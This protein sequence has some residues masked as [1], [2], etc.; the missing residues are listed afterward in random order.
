MTAGLHCLISGSSSLGANE[1]L[2]WGNDSGVDT[3]ASIFLSNAD[4][5]MFYPTLTVIKVCLPVY[6]LTTDDF[7]RMKG[8]RCYPYLLV[9]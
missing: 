1:R 2:C 9:L 5:K 8:L 6:V 7:S 3:D 4:S